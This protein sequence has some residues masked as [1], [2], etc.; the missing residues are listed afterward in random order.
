M[1]FNDLNADGDRDGTSGE[2][3]I[4]DVTIQLFNAGD[5]PLTDTPLATTVTG[6]GTDGRYE[7]DNLDPG[8]YF[9]FIP[10]SEFA[11]GGTLEGI[12]IFTRKW[13]G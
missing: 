4:G 12:Y 3:R 13:N 6:S 9:V 8:Q 2:N 1:V 5:D 10:P 7:F 11:P